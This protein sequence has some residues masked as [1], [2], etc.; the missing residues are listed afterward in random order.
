MR[1]GLLLI[2]GWTV[3]LVAITAG[4]MAFAATKSLPNG[5]TQEFDLVIAPKA[6]SKTKPTPISVKFI[7]DAGST[8]RST[9]IPSTK[10]IFDFDKSVAVY[11]K[12]LPVCKLSQIQN[13]TTEEAQKAC[14][15]A[16]IGSGNAT[17]ELPLGGDEVVPAPGKVLIFN[18]PTKGG[19][20]TVLLH[21]YATVPAPQTLILT[22]TYSH[23][24]KQ[25][26]GLRLTIPIPPLAGGVASMT[27]SLTK[28][29]RKW[30][31]KGQKRSYFTA[32]CKSGK[33]KS[34]A[35]YTYQDGQKSEIPVTHSCTPRS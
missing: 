24:N 1:K 11:A 27:K 22:G 4:S 30:T 19:M 10:E 17:A 3:A 28:F 12:G 32:L 35:S 20:P 6:L 8:N 23:Y 33:L 29:D 5:N 16:K 34:R 13:T 2:A 21:S 9:P 14:G 25:G 26:Y 15:P 7:G 18:G 31:Y